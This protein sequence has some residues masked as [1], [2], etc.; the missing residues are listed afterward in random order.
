MRCPS[1]QKG[2]TS[3]GKQPLRL[4]LTSGPGELSPYEAAFSA[5]QGVL[6]LYPAVYSHCITGIL[7][8]AKQKTVV[9]QRIN[10][11][12]ICS[13]HPDWEKRSPYEETNLTNKVFK[14]QPY[15]PTVLDHGYLIAC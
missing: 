14:N 11:A 3:F 5:Q 7:K 9:L 1:L 15:C 4:K 8:P 13:I 10:C 12:C 6:E 2:G